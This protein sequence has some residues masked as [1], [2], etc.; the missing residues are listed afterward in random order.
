M[1]EWSESAKIAIDVL[2][3]C[4]IV[5]TMLVVSTVVRNVM[6]AVDKE[7][8]LNAD[9][10]EF[11]IQQAYDDTTC[12]AQDIVSLVLEY[13]GAPS[14]VVTTLSG[15]TCLWSSESY[16]TPLT[17]AAISGALNQNSLYDCTLTYD[18]NG[19]VTAFNFKEVTTP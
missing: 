18:A 16:H 12:Y 11:R 3:A 19:T 2:I 5:S 9:I 7:R 1:E 17:A 15:S 10:A 14:V 8:T 4:I 6:R 13:Q